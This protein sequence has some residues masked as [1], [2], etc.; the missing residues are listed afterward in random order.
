MVIWYQVFCC[1]SKF[2]K[3]LSILWSQWISNLKVG[4]KQIVLL[5]QSSNGSFLAVNYVG[6]AECSTKKCQ[7][8]MPEKKHSPFLHH[9]SPL[10]WVTEKHLPSLKSTSSAMLWRGS[11]LLFREELFYIPPPRHRNMTFYCPGF[12]SLIWQVKLYV[13]R[14]PNSKATQVHHSSVPRKCQKKCNWQKM[15]YD[16]ILLKM[17]PNFLFLASELHLIAS[18]Y[19]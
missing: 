2:S 5:L 18:K 17:G 3:V 1:I 6:Y 13:V 10:S 16:W 11:K 19:P 7:F 9:C 15:R 12:E 8:P 4:F 14:I